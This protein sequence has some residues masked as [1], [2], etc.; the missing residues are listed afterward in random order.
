M[1]SAT[2]A[3][4][5]TASVRSLVA[6]FV[7]GVITAA[8]HA[9]VAC[10]SVPWPSCR[11]PTTAGK[12]QLL[13]KD[14]A[15]DAKDVLVWKWDKG[16]ATTAAEF[17]QP[18][19]RDDYALCLYDESS[20]TPWLVVA[21]TIPADVHCKLKPCWKGLGKPP[22]SKGYRYADKKMTHSNVA[23]L[24]LKPGGIGKA[25]IMAKAKGADLQPLS[26]PLTTP[27]ALRV[28]LQGEHGECWEAAYDDAGT[29]KNE[30][31]HYKGAGG[32]AARP[33]ICADDMLCFFVAP[34]GDDGADGSETTPFATLERARAA[35]RSET[36]N[37]P[38]RGAVVYLRE[39][40][41]ARTDSFWLTGP[42][43][44][45]SPGAPTTWRN[46]P[47]ERP[48]ISGA[49]ILPELTAVTSPEA[50]ER[51]PDIH[52]SN[53]L[54]A[55]L[56][57]LGLTPD[58]KPATCHSGAVAPLGFNLELIFDGRP[59]QIARWPD[60]DW[61]TGL[62]SISGTGLAYP[63]PSVGG[64]DRPASWPTIPPHMWVQVYS[65]PWKAT[66]EP[67]TNI[68]T[69]AREIHT[70]G[71]Q[72][73]CG[74]KCCRWRVLNL[75]EELDRPGEYFFDPDDQVLYFWPPGEVSPENP[76]LVSIVDT[77]LFRAEG[78][79]HLV[80]RGLTFEASRQT[81]IYI[82]L[83]QDNHVATCRFRNLASGVV[84]EQASFSG[85]RDSEFTETG[86]AI[87][88]GAS[89][90]VEL[91][92]ENNV[93]ERASRWCG[94]PAVQVILGE[95]HRILA[96]RLRE[97]PG[98]AIEASGIDHTISRNEIGNVVM[99]PDDA[100]AIY[101]G[102]TASNIAVLDNCL[103]DVRDRQIACPTRVGETWGSTQAT[104]KR[105]A[106]Y[107]DNCSSGQLIGG[108]TFR[109]IDSA[110]WLGGGHDTAIAQNLF[111]EVTTPLQVDAR[112]TRGTCGAPLP[113]CPP[114]NNL[115]EHNGVC[116]GARLLT[117]LGD[118]MCVEPDPDVCSL[119]PAPCVTC[120]GNW[121]A[122]PI[123]REDDGCLEKR[124]A[125]KTCKAS[126]CGDG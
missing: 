117:W 39:G 98:S 78:A 87:Q 93:I 79:S 89:A 82:Y 126:A 85:V 32:P 51:I 38:P 67:V 12:S 108:N 53:V 17:G 50:L 58:A 114:V 22:G 18:D 86:Q 1:H 62:A 20:G 48:A 6:V 41:Y 119:D 72:P 83:G 10:D 99:Q 100:G 42:D 80:L 105:S 123:D 75:L 66:Y 122:G 61:A 44:G 116:L 115:V 65:K 69:S 60:H 84:I 7:L 8:P 76:A 81:G 40:T 37:M 121:H 107:L 90:A 63:P 102:P 113:Q 96:N 94:S 34:M 70:G 46:Y 26:L 30:T 24:L 31:G 95:R 118:D 111:A 16:A 112:G 77:P 29:I 106:V 88:L 36:G 64:T 5:T 28:Q 21:A 19:E 56:S 43:S 13:L 3:P 52:E 45:V 92:A 71:V 47:G 73:D 101:L 57:S 49:A 14:H 104:I 35:V 103:H 97:L 109:R 23:K 11:N 9:A 4:C 74:G 91:Y 110:V 59:M 68:D 33:P 15:D 25:K 125:L 2:P 54:Q 124:G 120:T 55:D 27:L